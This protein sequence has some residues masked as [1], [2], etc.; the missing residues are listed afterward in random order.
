LETKNRREISGPLH[1]ALDHVKLKFADPPSRAEIEAEATS[2][3]KF[4][5]FHGKALLD[6]LDK[7][8]RIETEFQ[9]F[10]IQAI[11]F[12]SD[13]TLVAI[14]GEVVVDYSLR[15]KKELATENQIVWVAGYSNDGFGYLPSLRVLK[16]GGYEGGGAMRYTIFPG[17]FDETVED[18]VITKTHDLVARVRSGTSSS[19]SE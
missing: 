11:Q 15:L 6:Q 18:R 9:T 19:N 10:P 7:H 8:G 2:G 12:G 13:L 16:E 5:R 4:A 1:V 3:N 17:P 14:C